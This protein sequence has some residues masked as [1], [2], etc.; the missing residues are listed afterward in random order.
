MC[1][2][3][4]GRVGH[5]QEHL[6]QGAR[7][8]T[9]V[10]IVGPTGA[11]KTTLVNLLVRF[12]DPA[13]GAITI[14][15]HDTKDLTLDC[16]RDQISLVLQ[17]PLLFSGSIA[18]NIRYG[19]LEATMDEIV[20]AAKAANCHDFIEAFPTGYETELGEGGAQ[21]SGGERQRICVARAFIRDAPIL[22][23]DEPTSSIDSKTESVI[24]DAL[25]NLMVGRTSFM[26]AHRLSTIRDADLILVLNHGEL[27]EQGTHDELLARRGPLLPA[28]RGA[29]RARRPGSRPS[30]RRRR[31]RARP[32]EESAEIAMTAGAIAESEAADALAGDRRDA[33]REP[34]SRRTARRAGGRSSAGDRAAAPAHRARAAPRAGDAA[35]AADRQPTAAP[36]RDREGDRDARERGA[37]ARPGG[38]R[39]ASASGGDGAHRQRRSGT[40]T[41]GHGSRIRRRADDDA[42]DDA[43]PAQPARASATRRAPR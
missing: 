2:S 40:T 26:I 27:V 39:H 35:A 22:I 5:A 23:L 6:L 32:R 21:L 15:G 28:L 7:P 18:D 36:G 16:L 1:F 14:D 33:E 31:P 4:K 17:E 10:A 24:L 3:Y 20:A 37:A 12:Y 30:T 8:A 29:D 42:G 41:D 9:R 38:A 34:T 25:E 11:G 19:R 13:S 43:G